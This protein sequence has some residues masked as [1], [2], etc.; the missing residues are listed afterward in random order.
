MNPKC[1][2]DAHLDDIKALKYGPD[3]F[4][5]FDMVLNAL[6][7]VSARRHVNRICLAASIPLVESG[8]EG[9][10]GQV[11]PFLPGKTACYECTPQK[12]TT[13]YPV[14]TIRANPSKP[15]HT[16]VWS[17]QLFERIFGKVRPEEEIIAELEENFA[18]EGK[19]ENDTPI[20]VD[21]DDKKAL[22]EERKRS[23]G[24]YIFH[25]LFY[26]DVVQIQGL[27]SYWEKTA[28]PKAYKLD[29]IL[30]GGVDDAEDVDNT[31]LYEDQKIWSLR[32]SSSVFMDA[33]KK[34]LELSKTMPLTWDKDNADHL[35]F[36]TAASNIRSSQFGIPVQS[37]FTVKSDAGNIIPAIATTNAIIAGLIVS[38]AI[39][40]ASGKSEQCKQT[41]MRKMA[42]RKKL[43]VSCSMDDKNPNCYVCSSN[44]VKLKI[45]TAEVRLKFLVD[46]ILKSQL[47]MIHPTII[48]DN[49][50][51]F[52]SGEDVDDDFEDQLE[53][54]L[55]DV[56]IV[57]NAVV[58]VEDFSQDLSIQISIDNRDKFSFENP[59]RPFELTGDVKLSMKPVENQNNESDSD[60]DSD[61][62]L[63]IEQAPADDD[64]IMI[65]D[66]PTKKRERSDDDGETVQKKQ[67]V[68]EH[69]VD[70]HEQITVVEL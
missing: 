35:D 43:L 68:D 13:H 48:V 61:D 12:P 2:I 8:T 5:N 44:F 11:Q 45:D 18:E 60:N 17:K 3:Y 59:D 54:L 25:K 47:N 22:E 69:E 33:C 58:Q 28:P 30:N 4:K 70:G 53:K 27:K 51:I 32:K 19:E 63:I 42:V 65:I 21:Q 40:I 29:D 36:V 64:D 20:A 14:C 26:V 56:R 46:D 67:K 9:W 55:K 23:L 34:L 39:K 24:H 16:I 10:L 57:H 66:A 15:I 38:E 52:E 49:D 41:F 37:R 1:K 31:T 7:N 50:I 62:M 6:D